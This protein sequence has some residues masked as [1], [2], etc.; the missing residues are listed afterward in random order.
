MNEI[1]LQRLLIK[2]MEQIGGYGRKWASVYA[3]GLPDLIMIRNGRSAY[4]EMKY[5]KSTA[6][7]F[8]RKVDLTPKQTIELNKLQA[9]GAKAVVAVVIDHKD[10]R[11]MLI[12]YPPAINE[13]LI[14]SSE[15]LSDD[16]DCCCTWKNADKML[17]KLTK[18]Q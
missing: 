1:T 9:A 10:Q 6:D 4:V 13:D 8:R 3:V 15:M 16:N 12:M 18:E 14:V 7:K 11:F 5:I 17:I 2:K